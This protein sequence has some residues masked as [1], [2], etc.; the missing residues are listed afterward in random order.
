MRVPRLSLAAFALLLGFAPA[1]AR[2][3][4]STVKKVYLA[5]DDHTD[6][7]WTATEAEYYGYFRDMLDFYLDAANATAGETGDLQSRFTLD[8]SLWLKLYRDG[9]AQFAPTVS[10]AVPASPRWGELVNR[11]RDG[12]ITPVMTPLVV[13][14]GAVPAEAVLRS[15]YFPGHLERT[16]GFRFLLAQEVEVMT[17]PYGLGALWAGAGVKYS[18]KGV[19]NCAT[20]V[21]S[22]NDRDREIYRWRGPDGSSILMKWNSLLDPSTGNVDPDY[23]LPDPYGNTASPKTDANES[24]GGYAEARFPKANTDFVTTGA[25]NNGF[26]GRYPFDA[27]GL[28]GQGW[29]DR[30]MLSL[31]VQRF[32]KDDAAAAP[33][34]RQVVVSNTLD[35][36]RDFEARYG[37]DPRLTDFNA[38]F[39]NEWDVAPASLAEVSARVKRATEKLRAAEAMAAVVSVFN[40]GFMAGRDADRE[41]AF[42]DLGL[43]FEHDFGDGGPGCSAAERR[44]WARRLADEVDGYVNTLHDDARAALAALVARPGNNGANPRFVVFNPL[45]W[46]RTEAADL[47]WTGTAPVHVVDVATGQEVPA[48]LVPTAAAPQSLRVLAANV[49]SVGYRVFEVQPGAGG[50]FP[51]PLANPSAGVVRNADYQVTVAGRGA[52]T[53]LKDLAN[54]GL[55]FVKNSGLRFNDLNSTGSPASGGTVAVEG[56]VGPVSVT[57]KATATAPP[58]HVTRVTLY[59]GPSRRADVV[60]E[61]TQGF[62]NAPRYWTFRTALNASPDTR[63]EE[64]GAILLAKLTTAGGHY[65]PRNARY[66]FLTLNHF[67]SMTGSIGN[68]AAGLTLANADAFFLRLGNSTTAT[69]DTAT[70]DLHPILGGQLGG[71]GCDSQAGDSYFRQRFSLRTHASFDAPSEMRFALET[72]NPLVGAA[73]PASA[74]ATGPLPAG[75]YSFAAVDNA[76][77]LLWALKPHD[78]GPVRGLVARVWNLAGTPQTYTLTTARP[79]GAARRVTH[80]ETDD[81]TLPAPTVANGALTA[82]A[83]A[84]QLQTHRVLTAFEAWRE[85]RFGPDAANPALAGDNAD[86]DGNGVNNLLEYAFG[87]D[88]RAPAGTGVPPPVPGRAAGGDGDHLTLTFT[89]LKAATDLVYT[90]EVAADLAHGPWQSGPAVTEQTAVVDGGATERVTVRDLAPVTGNP[91]RFLRLRVSRR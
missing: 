4:T 18:W 64:I 77:V 75:S 14:W 50:T 51:N 66:D 42:L 90:V 70:P 59:A 74:N 38:S 17:L 52:I 69:L 8:G 41:R 72:Q 61:V 89:R 40:P 76:N 60:N 85:T 65:S 27:V 2:A 71:Y 81:A 33:P 67:A 80:V 6:F 54:G 10:P 9:S 29:D 63:H 56:S 34:G 13:N 1:T 30:R 37:S 62:D 28:F 45:G 88:P 25:A 78:D 20:A 87:L 58:A 19:C 31:N 39:G 55:E 53:S 47:P 3:Q 22:A 36:F 73:L 44:A 5:P 83:T 43:Y 35:F 79:V 7:L 21:P 86:P 24:V 82:N 68:V 91:R 15:M 23:G 11:L 26:L 49:P 32:A 57:L 16:H 46:T 12:H 84:F 48:Q